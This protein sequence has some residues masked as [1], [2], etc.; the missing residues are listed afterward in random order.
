MDFAFD[1]YVT[2]ALFDRHH[3]AVFA[4]GDGTVRFEDGTSVEAHPDGSVLCA[5]AHPSG[6]GIL[7]GGDDGR[8]VWSQA[9]GPQLVGE[10]KGRWIDSIAANAESGLIAFA[11]GKNLQVRDVA[12]AAFARQFTH[13]H[14]L[15]D[16]AFDPKG[17]RLGAATYGGVALWYAR[18][19]E[20][21]S[22]MLKWAGSHVGLVWSPDGKF[23]VSSMQEGQLHGWRLSD[24][25]NMQMGG[26]P[27]KVK[28]MCFLANGMIMATSGSNG[29][30]V[31]PFGGANGPMGK[32]ASEV[33]YD[34]GS[35]TTRVASAGGNHPFLAVGRDDGRVGVLNLQAT[36]NEKVRNT[37]S[38]S[39][40]TALALSTDA[41]RVAWG[42]EAGAAGV[43][44]LPAMA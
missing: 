8:V 43:Q 42:D 24:T 25:K 7:T 41:G 35:M 27:A 29:A 28:S 1:A 16:L 15:S 10:I 20:Q 21:K 38:G 5:C 3:R 39:P 36:H 9:S 37:P 33:A 17:R 14:S 26:Y 4:L 18:V 44:G 34:D 40:I 6:E 19:A 32:Q 11:A 2:A 12:D 30:V 31:W 13:D 23:I 22:A